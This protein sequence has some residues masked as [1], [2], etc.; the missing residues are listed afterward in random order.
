VTST[1]RHKTFRFGLNW[2]VLGVAV[3]IP[4]RPDRPF[5]LPVLW[6]L[7]CK[8]G[9]AGYGTRPETNSALA[10]RLA[11]ANPDRVF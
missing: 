11:E 3:T 7:Y 6:R 2:V 9:S 1:K 5:C 8:K 4:S 10:Q